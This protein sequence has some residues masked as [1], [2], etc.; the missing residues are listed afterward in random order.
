MNSIYILIPFIVISM[1]IFLFIVIKFIYLTKK[2]ER[3]VILFKIDYLNKR[4]L[5]LNKKSKFFNTVFDS[6]KL[7]FT[8][9]NYLSLNTFYD[10]INKEDL[11]KIK[12][13]LDFQVN[14][15]E[16]IDFRISKSA[17]KHLTFKEKIIWKIKNTKNNS[18][19][20]VLTINPSQD[21][22]YYCTLKWEFNNQNK[23]K[24]II[25]DNSESYVRAIKT[26]K[27]IAVLAFSLKTYY[28]INSINLFDIYKIVFFLNIPKK[29]LRF[30]QKDGLL[31]FV[32]PDVKSSKYRKLLSYAKNIQSLSLANK[33]FINGTIFKNRNYKTLDDKAL[34][35]KKAQFCI[36]NL[37][38]LNICK[39]TNNL[40]KLNPKT[41][42]EIEVKN[43][44]SLNV[45]YNLDLH[46]EDTNSFLDFHRNLE[47]YIH[48]NAV[49]K[50][51]QIKKSYLYKYGSEPKQEFSPKDVGYAD[52]EMTNIR[53]SDQRFFRNIPYLNFVFEPIWF[54]FIRKKQIELLK[55]ENL[56]KDYVKK[57]MV[58]VSQESYLNNPNNYIESSPSV[59]IYSYKNNFERQ[60]LSK[61]ISQNKQNKVAT[62][63]YIKEIDRS[64][65][66][67]VSV[68]DFSAVIIAKEIS[69]KIHHNETLLNCISLIS[70][71]EKKNI[72]IIYENAPEKLSKALT[73]MAKMNFV[74]D[75]I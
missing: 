67:T 6:K 30:F 35:I 46:A 31:F 71:C 42:E 55:E 73:N 19:F 63:L 17:S 74:I 41:T 24:K 48:E 36:F 53:E 15:K 33:Y 11:T 39:K 10:L 37:F 61:I 27:N 9:S 2:M 38:N 34:I 62:F 16:K 66:H 5:R 52:F 64:T 40:L 14:Q 50:N 23:T 28:Y 22:I 21:A 60:K 75:K 8:T 32:F 65:L 72:G 4:V 51:F 70:L 57:T 20:F 69:E 7:N 13:Y 1:T 45:F 18:I 58:K 54:D 44:E 56:K 68:C 25:E 3:G 59:V 29:S 47:E 43:K 26:N 12:D 49:A